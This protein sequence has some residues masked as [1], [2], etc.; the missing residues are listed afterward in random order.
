MTDNKQL[1]SC[2]TNRRTRRAWIAAHRN[3]MAWPTHALRAMHYFNEQSR[4]YFARKH[5]ASVPTHVLDKCVD[6]L[7]KDIKHT[8]DGSPSMLPE[9]Q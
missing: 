6:G 9:K 8:D 1:M 5:R 3:P 2:S 4:R 7:L